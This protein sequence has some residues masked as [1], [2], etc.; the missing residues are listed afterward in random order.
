MSKQVEVTNETQVT[1]DRSRYIIPSLHSAIQI[2]KYLSRAKYKT[3]TLTQISSDFDMNRSTTYRILTT[4]QLNS[5]VEY[6]PSNRTYRLGTE[7]AVLGARAVTLNEF[8]HRA[9]QV[10]ERIA[11]ETGNT[12]VLVQRI[13][14]DKI[15]YVLKAEPD[16]PIRISATLGQVYPITAGSHG[17]LFLA[18]MEL[19]ERQEILDQLG[20]PR[21]TE[22]TIPREKLEDE[23]ENIRNTG[24]AISWEEHFVG[25]AGVAVP[26]FQGGGQITATISSIAMTAGGSI[27]HLR[28][29]GSWMSQLVDTDL[30]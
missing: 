11:K 26:V 7:V 24:I 29:W 4:L 10:I 14:R 16:T 2:L 15:A 6:E 20:Y 3:A 30:Y 18:H 5:M 25:I 13:S 28:E 8:L 21:Y 22:Q 1:G 19:A 12:T 17:K 9:A 27:E 23:L